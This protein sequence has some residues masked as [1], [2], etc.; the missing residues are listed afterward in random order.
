MDCGHERG[1][2][3]LYVGVYVWRQ[4]VHGRGRERGREPGHEFDHA[5]DV[6]A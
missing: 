1:R 6:L 2:E 4:L 5:C 3:R